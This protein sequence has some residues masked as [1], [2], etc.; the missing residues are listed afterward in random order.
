[1]AA[2]AWALEAVGVTT[3][4]PFGP[5][6]YTP[7]LGAW[8]GPVPAAIPF[9]WVASVGSAYFTGLW[10]LDFRLWIPVSSSAIRDPHSALRTAAL[11]AALATALDG[12]LEPVATRVQGYWHWLTAPGAPGTLYAGIPLANFATWFGAALVLGLGIAAATAGHWPRRPVVA[13]VPILLYGLNLAMFG[14]VNATHGF[15]GPALGAAGL[16]GLLVLF[17]RRKQSERMG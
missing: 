13:G 6:Q 8:L 1:V 3:G 16:L 14:V 11:G 12:V 9:A 4:V 7:A 15:G 2:L 5:Y 10:I 17:S